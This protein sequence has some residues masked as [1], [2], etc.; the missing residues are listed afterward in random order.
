MKHLVLLILLFSIGTV[1]L[2]AQSLEYFK[3]SGTY[4]FSL[5]GE[6]IS[7]RE[8]V[9]FLDSY[10]Q[11]Q[12]LVKK[13]ANGYGFTNVIAL[14][15]GGLIGWP[16]GTA[17]GGGDPEW[18]LLGIGAGLVIVSIP[19]QNGANNKVVE[20]MTIYDQSLGRVSQVD[21]PI[22]S[23]EGSAGKVGLLVRF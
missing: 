10:P 23:I 7:Y 11:V 2:Q 1:G 8:A 4:K 17:L 6:R 21:R 14:I 20:G 3:K 5:D 22:I 18:A 12:E 15:G 19:I 9:N 13:A 16:I